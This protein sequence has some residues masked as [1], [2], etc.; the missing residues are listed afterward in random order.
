[1]TT[2]IKIESIS[3]QY[4]LGEIGTGSL[5]HDVNRWWHRVR[6]KEDPYLRIGE[7]NDRS[8]KGDSEYVWALKDVSFDIQQGEVVGIIGRNGAGKS[9][10]LK[11]LSRV[12][13]PTMGTI[14]ARGRIASLLEVGTGFHPE[15]TGRENIYLNGAI[16]G[17][18]KH[19]ITRKLDEIIDFSGCERYLDTPVKRYSSGMYVRLAFSVA[20]HLD[21]DIMI[22]DEVLA[23]GDA[24]FQARCLNRMEAASK[25]GQTILFVSHQLSAVRS[26]CKRVM[27]VENGQITV[28]A[29]SEA[30][31]NCYH[32]MLSKRREMQVIANRDHAE[33]ANSPVFIERF[34]AVDASGK[35]LNE[36]QTGR[37]AEFIFHLKR[38][39]LGEQ[40]QNIDLGFGLHSTASGYCVSV[41][42]SSYHGMR[43]AMDQNRLVV[44]CR[45]ASLPLQPASYFVYAGVSVNGILSDR[46]A[47]GVGE[48]RVILGDFYPLGVLGYSGEA[49][50]LL[51]T[52]WTGEP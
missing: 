1:M 20:A 42:W 30:A 2:A 28:D 14:K 47:D 25:S 17:M 31:I 18:R 33:L 51:T 48:F 24:D 16:L 32:K 10:L 11:I 19:E 41:D 6:G 50:L 45:I 9:T 40:I 37:P 13:S 44:R 12:T 8:K 7:A 21:P 27:V 43:F 5:A 29:D 23:V 4:R 26:I 35:Q 3:K 52:S 46:P 22:V 49:P 39:T 34:E 15:L 38:S 36:L